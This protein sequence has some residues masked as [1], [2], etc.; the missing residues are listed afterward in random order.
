MTQNM[1]ALLIGMG[2]AGCILILAAIIGTP[3][4]V[5]PEPEDDYAP[6]DAYI[7]LLLTKAVTKDDK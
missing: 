1:V 3:D 6:S 7:D 4:Y 5:E 2:L